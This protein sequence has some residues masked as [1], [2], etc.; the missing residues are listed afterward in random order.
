MVKIYGG[1]GDADLYMKKGSTPT[2]SSYDCHPYTSD[3]TETSDMSSLGAGTYYIM[4]LGYRAVIG[5]SWF[6]S[7]SLGTRANDLPQQKLI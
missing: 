7:C 2:S 5:F 4:V 3:N 1:T 6:P